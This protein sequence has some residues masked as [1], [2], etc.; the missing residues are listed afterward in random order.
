MKQLLAIAFAGILTA[1]LTGCAH[2]M[3]KDEMMK[4]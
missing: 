4:K 3:G 2:D 1:G